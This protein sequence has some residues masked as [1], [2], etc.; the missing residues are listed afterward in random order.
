M[1]TSNSSILYER[2]EADASK[3][4]IVEHEP[5]AHM[6][7]VRDAADTSTKEQKSMAPMSS[8][9][10]EEHDSLVVELDDAI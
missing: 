6:D 7:P 8:P 9:S 5:N 3:A 1:H 10:K 4:T 2:L